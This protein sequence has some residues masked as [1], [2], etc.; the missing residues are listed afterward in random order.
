[1]IGDGTKYHYLAI[2]KLSGLLQG[3]LSN[4]RGD[5]YCLNCFNS[6]TTKNKLKEHEEICNNHDSCRI[7]MPDWANKT[8]KYNPAPFSF[9]LDLECILKKLQSSQNNPE[10]SYTE[11]KLDMSLL[12]GRYIQDVHLI[13]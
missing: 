8:I 4:H 12:V 11:K 3:N 10:K 5:F 7:E 9:F 2:T 1:M 13:R 6:Y